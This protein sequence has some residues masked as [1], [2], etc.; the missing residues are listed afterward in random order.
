M[1]ASC[2]WGGVVT[3]AY[4]VYWAGLCSVAVTAL[5]GSWSGSSWWLDLIRLY[6]FE[7]VPYP[8]GYVCWSKGGPVW[9]QQNLCTTHECLSIHPDRPSSGRGVLDERPPLYGSSFIVPS[10][11]VGAV[12]PVPLLFY[13]LLLVTWGIFLAALVA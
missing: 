11:G 12:D 13:V 2:D 6:Y 10:K 9:S 7:C 1:D 4:T 5:S 3:R 8:Q